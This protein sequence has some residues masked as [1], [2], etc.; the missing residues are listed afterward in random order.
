MLRRGVVKKSPILIPPHV[1]ERL[2]KK[3]TPFPAV[4]PL[5]ESCEKA[6]QRVIAG[7]GDGRTKLSAQ[8][9]PAPV[10]PQVYSQRK[11]CKCF[12]FQQSHTENGY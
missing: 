1:G 9:S 11:S 2:W 12:G 4:P 10:E 5:G 7:A 8:L 6:R 3:A